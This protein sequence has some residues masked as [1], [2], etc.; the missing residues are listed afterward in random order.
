M[1]LDYV[2][3]FK[4]DFNGILQ[5]TFISIFKVILG[6]I[7]LLQKKMLLKFQP[8]SSYHLGLEMLIFLWRTIINVY[9]Q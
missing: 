9:L 4:K 5:L 7:L 2:G 1:K 8:F 3:E 6:N